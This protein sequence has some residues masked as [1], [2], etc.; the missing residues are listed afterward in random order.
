M[1]LKYLLIF[2]RIFIVICF[3]TLTS[4][5]Q[6]ITWNIRDVLRSQKSRFS[7]TVHGG[8]PPR[9]RGSDRPGLWSRSQSQ[10]QRSWS[11]EAAQ[12]N[13]HCL[14]AHRAPQ[15]HGPHHRLLQALLL[16][17][18][19]HCQLDRDVGVNNNVSGCCDVGLCTWMITSF[20]QVYKCV[21]LP[22]KDLLCK[23]DRHLAPV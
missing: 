21:Q 17:S 16:W 7:P 3:N 6:L 10:S 18:Y 4:K 19:Y 2:N 9:I 11:K 15:H 8:P 23:D 20:N 5:S 14:R 13:P 12:Q 22:P 1:N